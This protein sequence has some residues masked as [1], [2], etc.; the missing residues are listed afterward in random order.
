MQIYVDAGI[1]PI[2]AL[3]LAGIGNDPSPPCTAVTFAAQICDC[4]IACR[5]FRLV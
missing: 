3:Q 4:P 2:Q 1:P 5:T